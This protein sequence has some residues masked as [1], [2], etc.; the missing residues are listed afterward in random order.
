[1]A[2]QETLPPTPF[3]KCV[4][5]VPAGCCQTSTNTGGLFTER[6]VSTVEQCKAECE[7]LD[8]EPNQVCKG[9]EFQKGTPDNTCKLMKN[10]APFDHTTNDTCG[11]CSICVSTQA[12]SPPSGNNVANSE[13]PTAESSTG[14]VGAGVAVVLVVAALGA[15]KAARGKSAPPSTPAPADPDMIPEPEME[16]FDDIGEVEAG[17]GLSLSVFGEVNEIIV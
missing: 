17:L 6:N 10:T 14:A 16:F 5:L 7:S 1:V 12:P 3:E 4:D 15:W 2:S 13:S 11:I 8:A 9:I